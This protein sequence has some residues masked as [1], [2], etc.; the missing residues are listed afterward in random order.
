[1]FKW[2][3]KVSTAKTVCILFNKSGKFDNQSLK[4]EFNKQK[5][6]N[7]R[8]PKFLGVTLDPGLTFKCYA[9][10]IKNRALRRLNILKCL[11]GKKW[12]LSLKLCFQ[13]TK[14]WLGHQLTTFHLYRQLCATQIL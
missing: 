4:L 1:M 10:E 2:R 7:E 13:H 6:R 14:Y 5:L 9:L 11:K 8:N 3:C 12:G